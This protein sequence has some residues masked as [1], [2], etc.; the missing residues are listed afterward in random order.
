MH[1]RQGR[2]DYVTISSEQYPMVEQLDFVDVYEYEALGYDYFCFNL[3]QERFQDELVRQALWYGYDQQTVV[4]VIYDGL[5]IPAYA[6]MPTASWA[7]A[8]DELNDYAYNPDRA[9]ELFEEAGWERGADGI[10]EKDDMRMEFEFLFSDATRQIEQNMLLFQQN[11]EDIGVD[12]DLRPME[13]A[14]A[15]DRIDAR[16][17]DMFALG[18]NLGVDPDPYTIWHSTSVW[19][20]AGWV[21]E[22]SD[23][24][25]EAGR[26]TTDFEERQ[27]IYAEWQQ[28]VNKEVPNIFNTYDIAIAAANERIRGLDREDPTSQG[29]IYPLLYNQIWIPADQQ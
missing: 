1:L 26:R 21:N 28:I 14:A 12:V 18:W 7:Y 19:N 23:E 29:I 6:P 16:E 5:A 25:I 17:F 10:W 9:I 24:L 27:E 13:F 3:R 15:V 8:G 4:D 11:M 22:R 20:D 2:I